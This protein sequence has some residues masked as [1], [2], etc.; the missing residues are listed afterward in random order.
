MDLTFCFVFQVQNIQE[1][2]TVLKN[3]SAHVEAVKNESLAIA[4]KYDALQV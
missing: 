4:Q 1:E 2:M 3:E